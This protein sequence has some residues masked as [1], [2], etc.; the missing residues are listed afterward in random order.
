VGHWTNDVVYSRLAP[1][2]LN[3]LKEIN[4]RTEKG[5]RKRRHHQYMIR[6]YGHPAL[7]EHLANVI[8]LMR[9]C[10]DWQDFK[11]RLEAAAPKHG[12]TIPLPLDD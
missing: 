7:K 9:G 12:D 3:K 10:R 2:V 8:F 1:G 11:R 6:D 4:P 5:Y